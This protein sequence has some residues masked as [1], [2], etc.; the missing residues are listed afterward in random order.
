[1]KAHQFSVLFILICISISQGVS[2]MHQASVKMITS[3]EDYEAQEIK[4]PLLVQKSLNKI[5]TGLKM[6]QT[7]E[8][9]TT[10]DTTATPAT[11]PTTTPAAQTT[12]TQTTTATK[13]DNTS[14]DT[15]K[16]TQ[17]TTTTTDTKSDGT[18]TQTKTTEVKAVEQK[19][20]DPNSSTRV[21]LK[22]ISLIA[23]SVLLF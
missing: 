6:N 23:V 1:M 16:T 13:T 14:G 18:Q 5:K 4:V 21:T 22:Y 8:A 12:T 11:T 17:T 3:F 15:A 10:A 2:S 20:D 9:T 7:P 19:P